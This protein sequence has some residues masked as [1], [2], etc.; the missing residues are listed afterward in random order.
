VVILVT[1]KEQITL[2]GMNYV[3]YHHDNDNNDDHQHHH[4]QIPCHSSDKISYFRTLA[5]GIGN[6][7][8]LFYMQV[9]TLNTIQNLLTP[10]HDDKMFTIQTALELEQTGTLALFI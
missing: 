4:Y 6:V 2:T 9:N 3:S 1:N 8:V 7:P 5:L 10:D